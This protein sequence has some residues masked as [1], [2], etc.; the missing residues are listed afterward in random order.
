M[1]KIYLKKSQVLIPE[2]RAKDI[3]KGSAGVRAQG[4][5]A[6]GNLMM[7]FDVI[8]SNNQIHVLNSPSPA[9]TSSLAIAD[10][11]IKNYIN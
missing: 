2:I 4:I 5:D 9:A 3:S 1:K 11:I 8:K 7:D 10:Y 6:K